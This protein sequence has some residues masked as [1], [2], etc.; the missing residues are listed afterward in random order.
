MR[1]RIIPSSVGI[2]YP[3][4]QAW[5][6]SRIHI[7]RI[8]MPIT[9][10][11]IY[12]DIDG[13]KSLHPGSV[14]LMVN[15]CTKN[16]TVHE[17][18]AY[19]HLFLNFRTIPP[20]LSREMLEVRAEDDPYLHHLVMAIA[21]VIQ[22][23]IQRSGRHK[24]RDKEDPA[25]ERI[26]PV[27]EQIVR[28]FQT[29]YDVCAAENPLLDRAIHY[30]ETNY[31]RALRNDEI[32]RE[33]HIDTRHLIRLFRKHLN[34]SP[35]LYLTQCRMG[36]PFCWQENPFPRPQSSADIKT[37]MHSALRSRKWW[38]FP[39][40]KSRNNHRGGVLCTTSIPGSAKPIRLIHP[41]GNLCD[42]R[43]GMGWQ[44]CPSW[45]RMDYEEH[46]NPTGRI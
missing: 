41:L 37:K 22:E 11:M 30:I 7:N 17:D 29:R 46:A 40:S 43:R 15:S 34:I 27:L 23:E 39:Q 19:Y 36:R 20:L 45:Q 35:H 31:A 14:Y 13:P 44:T 28:H 9:G 3:A 21:S 18:E 25:W 4:F 38:A 24:L 33:L 1:C 2:S 42:S 26:H 5:R 12:H 32:A 6:E 8:H 16:Y 10:G